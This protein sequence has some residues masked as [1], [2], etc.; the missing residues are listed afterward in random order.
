[1]ATS[2]SWKDTDDVGEEIERSL[3]QIRKYISILTEDEAVK[4]LGV[5][6]ELRNRD[7][8]PSL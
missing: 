6:M 8:L 3:E 4:I 7:I 1:M 2:V 5:C